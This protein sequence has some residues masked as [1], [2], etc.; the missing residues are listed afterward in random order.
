MHFILQRVGLHTI[1]QTTKLCELCVQWKDG[2]LNWISLKYIENSHPVEVAD[3]KVANR[4]QQ[5]P[6]FAW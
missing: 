5:E 4:I 2:L 1:R 3:Y 6:A